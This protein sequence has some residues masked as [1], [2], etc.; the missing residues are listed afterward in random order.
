MQDEGEY[1]TLEREANSPC[2]DRC[3]VSRPMPTAYGVDLIPR[4]RRDD[5]RTAQAETPEGECSSLCLQHSCEWRYQDSAKTAVQRHYFR[6]SSPR[7][8]T[9]HTRFLRASRVAP[10]GLGA[11]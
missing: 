10:S 11:I 4:L 2:P 7:R 6:R 9:T 3:L 5:E 1:W 8:F